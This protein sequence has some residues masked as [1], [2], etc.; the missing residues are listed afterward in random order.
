MSAEF[1]RNADAPADSADSKFRERLGKTL[2]AAGTQ[3][4]PDRA[5]EIFDRVSALPEGIRESAL[6]QIETALAEGKFKAARLHAEERRVTYD[7]L[8]GAYPVA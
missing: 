5:K 8:S 3:F 7:L 2:E 4:G 1:L 6:T